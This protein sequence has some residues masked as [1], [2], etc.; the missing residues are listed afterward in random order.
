MKKG[1]KCMYFNFDNLLKEM[2]LEFDRF[3]SG[4]TYICTVDAGK[5]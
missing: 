2:L 5:K 4:S 3:F 1:K